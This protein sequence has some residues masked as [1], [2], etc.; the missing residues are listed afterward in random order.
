MLLSSAGLFALVFG[1][2]ESSEYGWLVAKKPWEAFGNTYE[3]GG[4]SVSAYAIGI[5]KISPD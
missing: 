1:I 3:L 4:Y 5:E 2:I